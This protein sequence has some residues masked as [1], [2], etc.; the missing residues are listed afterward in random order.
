MLQF[1]IL[2]SSDLIEFSVTI[3]QSLGK[4]CVAF[5]GSEIQSHCIPTRE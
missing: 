3:N 2:K 5:F 4:L 1:S